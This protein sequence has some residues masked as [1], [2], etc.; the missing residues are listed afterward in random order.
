MSARPSVAAALP[1]CCIASPALATANAAD[2]G[3]AGVLADVVAVLVPVLLIIAVLVAVLYYARRRYRLTGSGAALSVVQILPVGPRERVVVV[4]TR[5]DR[6]L[7]V[8]VGAQTLSLLAELDPLD[9]A[10]APPSSSVAPVQGTPPDR[11][12]GRNG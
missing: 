4:R 3:T 6:Y 11:M 2:A 12:P 5:N 7:A 9:V 8:G 1:A 10:L